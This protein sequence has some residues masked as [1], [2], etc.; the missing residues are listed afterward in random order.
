MGTDHAHPDSYRLDQR[1]R[2][3]RHRPRTRLRPRGRERHG[4]RPFVVDAHT[5]GA[6]EQARSP[7]G[8]DQETIGAQLQIALRDHAA[9]D[10]H[11]GGGRRREQH[12]LQRV[13]G[14]LPAARAIGEHL[15]PRLLPAPPH[16]IAGGAHE[17]GPV[18]GLADTDGVEQFV[19]AGW[20][21]HREARVRGRP[22]D[23][24][25]RVAPQRQ[26]LRGAGARRA[27]AEHDHVG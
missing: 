8:V 21:G 20:N 27:A 12:L 22:R 23:Q 16:G 18:D 9:F 4:S 5:P 25:H 6:R 14:R 13:S 10:R 19:A 11:A 17:P 15:H 7:G 26:Q 24:A 2:V 1:V 3:V